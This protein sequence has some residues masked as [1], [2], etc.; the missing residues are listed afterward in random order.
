M[1]RARFPFRG[2]VFANKLMQYPR[3]EPA[4][5][6]STNENEHRIWWRRE[7]LLGVSDH[8]LIFGLESAFQCMRHIALLSNFN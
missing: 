8:L 6:F 3:E 5:F 2:R 4:I 1:E 7:Y